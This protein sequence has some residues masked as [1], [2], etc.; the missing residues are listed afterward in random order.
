MLGRFGII[1]NPLSHS[2]SPLLFEGIFKKLNLD[3]IYIPFQ[4]RKRELAPFLQSM[5]IKG[6]DGLNVTIPFKE[7]ILP[8][9]D[10]IDEHAEKIRA[11][12]TIKFKNGKTIGFNTDYTGFLLSIDEFKERGKK[13]L[14]FG[15]GGAGR[16]VLYALSLLSCEEILLIERNPQRREIL[17]ND[18]RS[19][20]DLEIAE[21]REDVIIR[22]IEE[23]DFLV[24]ATP[25]G[26]DGFS[27]FPSFRSLPSLNNKIFIDLIYKPE[28]TPFLSIGKSLGAEIKNGLDMLF[29]QAMKSLEIWTGIKTYKEDW[30]KVYNLLAK[31]YGGNLCLDI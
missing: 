30:E 24:N 10:D 5:K 12:N 15:G 22:G 6:F 7:E 8:L 2:L 17:K 14:V 16:A 31:P 13:V 3:F 1:G 23:A 21:W 25:L 18:F 27:T 11:V 19:V 9:L 26:M 29:Y 28:L 20:K 4:L